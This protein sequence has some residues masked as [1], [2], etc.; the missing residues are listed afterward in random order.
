M[1]PGP[2]ARQHRLAGFTMAVFAIVFVCVA[3]RLAKVAGAGA[4]A[5]ASLTLV[6]G[7]AL[8]AALLS[9]LSA[10]VLLQRAAALAPAGPALRG[11]VAGAAVLLAAVGVAVVLMTLAQ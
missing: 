10:V 8:S 6:L 2:T 4:V 1:S 5:S 7:V 3:A 9:L 11:W